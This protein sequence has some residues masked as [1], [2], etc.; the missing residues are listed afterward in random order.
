MILTASN[1]NRIT[2][3]TF[4]N[5]SNVFKKR[6]FDIVINSVGPMFCTEYYVDINFR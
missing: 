5:P 6:C 2:F 4:T 1:F 3:K